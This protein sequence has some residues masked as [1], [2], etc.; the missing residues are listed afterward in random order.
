[1]ALE[2]GLWPSADRA[3]A[4][5]GVAGL[6]S[7]PMATLCGSGYS[8]F[9][10]IVIRTRA[11]CQTGPV[12]LRRHRLALRALLGCRLCQPGRHLY[13]PSQPW[14]S[15]ST[16]VYTGAPPP[17]AI[18]LAPGCARDEPPRRRERESLTL[19]H[20]GGL[21]WRSPF[22]LLSKGMPDLRVE[23]KHG[24]ASGDTQVDDVPNPK[25]N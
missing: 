6:G 23:W 5:S 4:E 10:N 1:M 14:H 8:R 20:A 19:Q 24:S 25:P 12:A 17:R 22:G 2:C 21:D 9:L 18:N 16:P 11:A 15:M 3:A 13:A 7:E